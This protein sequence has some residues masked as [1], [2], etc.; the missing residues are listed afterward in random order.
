MDYV[1]RRNDPRISILGTREIAVR[2]FSTAGGIPET[3]I[4]TVI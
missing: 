3:G 4:D 2:G 1:A